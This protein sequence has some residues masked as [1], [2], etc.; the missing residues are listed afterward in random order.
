MP[1]APVVG[2][3]ENGSGATRVR[4]FFW[5]LILWVSRQTEAIALHR[6]YCLVAHLSG[7]CYRT[8]RRGRASFFPGLVRFLTFPPFACLSCRSPGRDLSV[9]GADIGLMSLDGI[10]LVVTR[11]ASPARIRLRSG[12]EQVSA[13]TRVPKP[14][15]SV[16]GLLYIWSLCSS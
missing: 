9:K 3:P 11:L 13:R 7:A 8:A 2:T 6:K 10:K 16:T 1:N 15:D 4:P 12:S 14:C 5:V